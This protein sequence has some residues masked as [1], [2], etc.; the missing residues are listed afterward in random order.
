MKTL[1]AVFTIVVV[2]GAIFLGLRATKTEAPTGPIDQMPSEENSGGRVMAPEDLSLKV[3]ES[4]TALGG[5]TLTLNEV[6]N[7]Y[8]CPTDVVCIEAGAVNTNITI[9]TDLKTETLNYSSDGVPMEFE[10]YAISIA[11]VTP[12]THSGKT[13]T[14]GEYL[15]TYHVESA[16]TNVVDT[17]PVGDNGSQCSAMGGTWDSTF[18][19]CLGIGANS[20]QE[21]G[22]VWNECASACRNDPSVEVCT[23]Q[24]VQVCEFDPVK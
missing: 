10:G 16:F 7:D 17:V 22:G 1:Y 8:R 14:Q 21:I 12:N 3:G 4:G 15:V 18:H 6:V 11:G 2:F 20:C 19:E 24:C 5:L 23:M 9:S 13:I